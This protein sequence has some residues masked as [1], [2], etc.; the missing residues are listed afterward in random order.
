VSRERRKI[1]GILERSDPPA[2]HGSLTAHVRRC[3]EL[4]LDQR[5][6]VFFEHA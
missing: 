3:E 1:L 2:D 4:R 5:E 6:V